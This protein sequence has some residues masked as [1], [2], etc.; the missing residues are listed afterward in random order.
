MCILPMALMS[1][2]KRINPTTAYKAN[3][4]LEGF[5]WEG[6]TTK[7]TGTVNGASFPWMGSK[8]NVVKVKLVDLHELV[9]K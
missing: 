4:Q 7:D 5:A 3:M 8:I 1:Q 6:G 2:N 9:S